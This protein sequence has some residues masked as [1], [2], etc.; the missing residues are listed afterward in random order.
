MSRSLVDRLGAGI[1]A[2][3]VLLSGC[4]VASE[5]KAVPVADNSVPFALLEP[6]SAPAAPVTTVIAGSTATIY[7]V[8]NSL[9]VPVERSVA[10]PTPAELIARLTSDPTDAEIA[11]GL[12]SELA[13]EGGPPLVL[14]SDMNR[15]VATVDLATGFTNL[16][17]DSQLFAIAQ[18]VCTLTAQPGTGQVAFTLQNA[19]VDVPLPG[20]TTTGDPVTAADYAVLVNP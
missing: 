20:G 15:G 8:K 9:I 6:D 5:H 10:D 18:I 11:A 1:A 7:L 17:S 16:D 3:L 13:T 2:G 4:A 14:G 19:P 12:R